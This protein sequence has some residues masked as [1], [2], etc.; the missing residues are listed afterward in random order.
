MARTSATADSSTV[1]QLL[2][3]RFCGLD[4]LATFEISKDLSAAQGYFC[5][6][7]ETVC[8]GQCCGGRPSSRVGGFLYDASQIIRSTADSIHLPFD[9]T[10]VVDNLRFERYVATTKG[11]ARTVAVPGTD[12]ECLLWYTAPPPSSHQASL[13]KVI[14]SGLAKHPVSSWPVDLSVENV[15]ERLLAASMQHRGIRKVPFIWFWPDGAP[16]C[17]IIT[18]DV[19][20]RAG[21]DFCPVLMDLNDSFGIKTS[22]QIVPENRYPASPAFLDSIRTRGFELPFKTSTTM[23]CFTA[24]TA[25]S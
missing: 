25:S 11:P 4:L 8:Y 14:F 1:A 5:L 2:K 9:P 24:T 6:G 12:P 15:F 20:T 10:Q 13:S 16:S 7:P 17:T 18:H 23:D 3:T 21:A 19:E 22:F